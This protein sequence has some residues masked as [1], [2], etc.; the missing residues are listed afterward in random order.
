[1]D[2]VALLFVWLTVFRGSRTGKHLYDLFAVIVHTGGHALFLVARCS[3]HRFPTGQM[4]TGHYIC[5]VR[6]KRQWYKCDD[7]M[8]TRASPEEVLS[9]NA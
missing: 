2:S 1:M 8:V 6:Q 4:D 9:S 5:Y 3:R 7:T